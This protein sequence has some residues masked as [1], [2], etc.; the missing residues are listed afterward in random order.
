MARLPAPPPKSPPAAVNRFMP[1]GVGDICAQVPRAIDEANAASAVVLLGAAHVVDTVPP[2][3]TL[4]KG[5]G[6][7]CVALACGKTIAPAI[8]V[9]VKMNFLRFIVLLSKLKIESDRLVPS[10]IGRAHV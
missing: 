7:G 2:P 3:T 6:H 8:P 4:T 9:V 10:E 5:G 1:V